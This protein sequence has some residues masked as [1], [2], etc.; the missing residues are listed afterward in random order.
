MSNSL[1]AEF[2]RVADERERIAETME[3]SGRFG[4][5]NPSPGSSLQETERLERAGLLI[6][7]A[8][9]HGYL[10]NIPG[11]KDRIEYHRETHLQGNKPLPGGI[12]GTLARCGTNLLQEV[13]EEVMPAA[14][15]RRFPKTK[16]TPA[17]VIRSRS[18]RFGSDMHKAFVE[19]ERRTAAVFRFLG[20]K[21]EYDAPLHLPLLGTPEKLLAHCLAIREHLAERTRRAPRGVRADT[22]EAVLAFLRHEFGDAYLLPAVEWLYNAAHALNLGDVPAL[23]GEPQ[24]GDEAFRALDNLADWCR[25]HSANPPGAQL[26]A[27]SR[28]G[29][30]LCILQKNGATSKNRRW[31]TAR[32]EQALDLERGSCK[33]DVAKLAKLRLVKTLTGP[34]G[35]V[36][37][38]RAGQDTSPRS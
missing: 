6:I 30:V 7:E 23:P 11:L 14:Y 36:W 12:A 33:R 21:I 32:I 8:W 25:A 5:T 34:R 38:T 24:T 13:I 37:L 15:P 20:E 16:L 26:D 10:R 17:F 3:A 28:P 4:V 35:G 18:E 2:L 9:E 1:A 29:M 22:R 27:N 31:P 19:W